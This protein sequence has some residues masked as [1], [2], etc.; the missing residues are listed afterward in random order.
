MR[1]PGCGKATLRP[2]A[3][4]ADVVSVCGS[5]Q[6]VWLERGQVGAFAADPR[7]VEKQFANLRD[8]KPG[9]RR[10][11]HCD[12]TLDRGRLPDRPIEVDA[13]PSCGGLWFDASELTTAVGGD[14]GLD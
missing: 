8:R 12:T 4:N 13:C 1:C 9:N 6:G 14:T 2:H 3:T 11:P 5:C 10:C 7:A